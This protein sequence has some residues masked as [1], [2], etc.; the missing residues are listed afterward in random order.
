M[1]NESWFKLFVRKM[2]TRRSILLHISNQLKGLGMAKR[3]PGDVFRCDGIYWKIT[4]AP[5]GIGYGY[6]YPVIRCTKT[7]K[8]F[9]ATNGF[10]VSFIDSLPEDQIFNCGVGVKADIDRSVEITKRKNR[11]NFL[12]RKICAYERELKKL[13]ADSFGG[14]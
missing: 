9:K 11:I 8:E 1:T 12:T 13:Y 6:S 5:R 3:S 4:G 2:C 14:E 10:S 7:G